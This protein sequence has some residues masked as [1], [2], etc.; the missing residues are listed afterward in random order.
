[1]PLD[2][3]IPRHLTRRSGGSI[4]SCPTRR[5]LGKE[6]NYLTENDK[7]LRHAQNALQ[8]L[9]EAELVRLPNRRATKEARMRIPTTG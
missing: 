8:V 5:P 2:W 4:S 1:M 9:K 3:V 7:K 6:R